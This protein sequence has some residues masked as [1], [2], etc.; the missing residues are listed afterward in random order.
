M[1][2]QGGHHTWTDSNGNYSMRVPRGYYVIRAS[3]Q[4]YYK[5]FY[6]NRTNI[7]TA[8]IFN[9]LTDTTQINFSLKSLPPI[10][11]GDINGTV[12]D[13]SAQKGISARIIAFR[14][15]WA[16][17]DTIA[18]YKHYV[19][20]TDSLGNYDLPEL[21]PGQYFIL[22]VPLGQYVPSYY[23]SSG[24]PTLR[25]SL[26]TAITM[27]GSNI[28]DIDIFVNPILNSS[29]GFTWISGTVSSSSVHRFYW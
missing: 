20:D 28:S 2:S 12:Y 16:A 27:A 24:Q 22:A 11:L 13:S 10:P 18:F 14:E 15:W 21:P 19:T 25:W 23:T 8:D 9:L 5:L 17:N 26:A 6:N 4:G 1:P 7:L 3:K 29:I